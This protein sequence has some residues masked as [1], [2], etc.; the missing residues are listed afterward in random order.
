MDVVQICG[1]IGNQMFQ[2]SF[3]KVLQLQGKEVAYDISWY[4]SQTGDPV[5]PRP[6]RLDKFQV[7]G[8]HFHRFEKSNPIVY[9]KA[10]KFN[11]KLFELKNDNNFYG[12]WQYYVYY[13]RIVPIL[14]K[15]FELK[16]E[17]YTPEFLKMAEKIID[18]TSVSMHVRRGD[19][20]LHRIGGFKDL[21]ATYYFNAMKEVEG[22]LYIFSDDIP[23]CKETFKQAYF[24]RKITFVD[25]EDYLC[26]EL[27]KLC[28]HNINTNSTFSWWAALLNDNEGKKVICPVTYQG[29]SVENSIQYR[30][31]K[32]WIK[33]E[34]Y[35]IHF[36]R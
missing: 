11:P 2:Y 14:K 20:Q 9:E 19:Y 5:F 25:M 8:L 12:Y 26:F 4:S 23:W 1:G 6:F 24:K 28:K 34:D 36:V 15:E 27:M 16:T 13:E 3:G 29:D 7:T 21:P 32:D 30:Y 10:V 18:T 22:D 35:A 17:F 31:P 33:I